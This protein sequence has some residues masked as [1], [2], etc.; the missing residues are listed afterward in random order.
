MFFAP[1][2]SITLSDLSPE[3]MAFGSG[4]VNFFRITAGSFGASLATTFWQ[5]REAVHHTQ[6][7]ERVCDLAPQAAHATAG[8]HDAGL[9]G[10]SATAEIQS[11]LVHQSTL[12]AA[13]DIFGISG[14]LFLALTAVVW[15]AKRPQDGAPAGAH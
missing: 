4:L 5:R 15:L 1:L 11:M 13:N 3:R 8:L 9:T 2:I 6:L 10:G 14:W 12:L 7:V